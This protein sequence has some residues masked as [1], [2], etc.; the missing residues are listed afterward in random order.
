MKSINYYLNIACCVGL[1]TAVSAFAEPTPS[2]SPT[3]TPHS[4]PSPTP[5]GTPRQYPTPTPTPT[6]HSEPSATPTPTPG[7]DHGEVSLRGFYGTTSP[8]SL[9]VFYI[10][11][12]THVQIH[13]LDLT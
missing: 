10:E 11:K 1:C 12:N 5:S 13:M 9:M 4:E 3:S 2:P 8:G 6:P 7:G